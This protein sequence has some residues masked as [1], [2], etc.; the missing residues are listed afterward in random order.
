MVVL[1]VDV[2]LWTSVA[3]LPL[4]PPSPTALVSH[5]PG[6]HS[7]PGVFLPQLVSQ[8]VAGF[9][10]LFGQTLVRS[11]MKETRPEACGQFCWSTS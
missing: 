5:S 7:P 9:L 10:S 4:V 1:K 6:T 2:F 3:T 11:R 8:N